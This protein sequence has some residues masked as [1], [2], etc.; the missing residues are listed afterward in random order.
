M[1]IVVHYGVTDF[2]DSYEDL[3]GITSL[4]ELGYNEEVA[5]AGEGGTA[6]DPSQVNAIGSFAMNLNRNRV[7]SPKLASL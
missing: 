3:M 4:A 2:E 1:L 6:L 5:N 7:H